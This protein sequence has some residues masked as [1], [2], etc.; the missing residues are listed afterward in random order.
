MLHHC[1]D[2]R[3][4]LAEALRVASR[5]VAVKDHFRFGPMSER[6]LLWMDRVGNAAPGVLVRGRY[7]SPAD[8]IALVDDAGGDTTGL[9]WPLRIH[10]L[11]FRL[12]TRDELQFAARVVHRAPVVRA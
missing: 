10:D 7:F 11:P 8:W 3:K 5:V 2:P 9:A 4:V 6:L 12:V 1:E